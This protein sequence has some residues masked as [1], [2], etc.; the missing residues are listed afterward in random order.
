[1]SLKTSIMAAIFAEDEAKQEAEQQNQT[2]PQ[3]PAT[4]FPSAP[5]TA[6]PSAPVTSFPTTSFPT[7]PVQSTENPIYTAQLEK[8]LAVYENGFKELNQPGY[9][10]FEF[11][12]AVVAA[13]VDNPQI[14]QM[15]LTMAK[16]MDANVSKQSLLTQ[17]DFYLNEVTKV[18]NGYVSSGNT[19]KQQIMQD[20]ENETKALTNDLK[21]L[22]QQLVS[23]QNQIQEKQTK[24]NQV[25][26]IYQPKVD[27]IK[28]KMM[29]NDVAKDKIINSL[30]K[31]KNGINTNIN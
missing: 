19:K 20:K 30:N 23:I 13:G 12:Q 14:Y 7:T 17:S 29:A 22:Q 25:E 2:Q 24:L 11:Y 16:A 31:V 3:Q 26:I 1:M 18:Y 5:A 8:I 28:Y 4:A 21:N 9:D 15:A 6:F 10:F 27:E